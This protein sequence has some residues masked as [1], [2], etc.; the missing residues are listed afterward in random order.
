M[1]Q[2]PPATLSSVELTKDARGE[3]SHTTAS[4]TSSGRAARFD[5]KLSAQR[6]GVVHQPGE[7]T[8]AVDGLEKRN[9]VFLPAEVG[10]HGGDAERFGEPARDTAAPMPPLPPVTTTT[11]PFA[12]S[13]SI[14]R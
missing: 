1:A 10:V 8:D 12:S 4:A 9:D 13:S 3:S 11:R 7:R 2:A 6:A 5:A 14:R